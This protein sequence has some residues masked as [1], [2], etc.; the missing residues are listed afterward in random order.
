MTFALGT[1]T[2]RTPAAVAVPFA[3]PAAPALSVTVTRST[4]LNPLPRIVSG[5]SLTILSVA[6]A[7]AAGAT[8]AIAPRR[9]P[10]RAAKIAAL[11]GSVCEMGVT[12]YLTDLM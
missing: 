1:E 12:C 6:F 5:F 4:G 8:V 11:P 9:M 3:V 2:V 7:D 10:R